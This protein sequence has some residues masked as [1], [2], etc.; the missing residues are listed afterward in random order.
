MS[1]MSLGGQYSAIGGNAFNSAMGR[2]ASM[3]QQMLG[4]QFQQ[5]EA[6]RQRRFQDEQRKKAEKAAD[7]RFWTQT[8]VGV[9]TGVLGGAITGGLAG[10]AVG[11]GIGGTVGGAT[12]PGAPDVKIEGTDTT[13]Q[14]QRIGSVAPVSDLESGQNIGMANI[15]GAYPST[16]TQGINSGGSVYRGGQTPPGMGVGGTSWDGGIYE[17]PRATTFGY[18]QHGG[19]P[20]GGGMPR[21]PQYQPFAG[22]PGRGAL[23]GG[24]LGGLDAVSGGHNLG[25]ALAQPGQNYSREL[26]AWNIAN[27][28]ALGWTNVGINAGRAKQQGDYQTAQT[29][30]TARHNKA[31]EL[32]TANTEIGR[33]N[34]FNDTMTLGRDKFDWSK[35][36]SMTV[37]RY[38]PSVTGRD[39]GSV[40][41]LANE[42]SLSLT[43]TAPVT[44]RVGNDG[45][46]SLSGPVDQLGSMNETMKGVTPFAGGSSQS[47][48]MT[49][50]EANSA[51][52]AISAAKNPDEM[53][54]QM[55][56]RFKKLPP[57]QQLMILQ[58]LDKAGKL[59]RNWIEAFLNGG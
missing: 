26:G 59:P 35:K 29:T 58:E 45:R 33:T 11:G 54:R 2:N 52:N 19:I 42:S 24:A 48:T 25:Y 41:D 34:R 46:T 51:I 4:Q 32:N 6:E 18:G 47:V 37:G 56:P 14:S 23:I 15:G 7:K 12:A 17:N 50:Q 13:G 9:G 39:I 55:A 5:A 1:L 53:F 36:P 3:R 21:M 27:D 8:G 40:Q 10:A 30:E 44:A 31:A 49:P 57:Q 38:G 22:G 20:N 28:N 16:A 43:P